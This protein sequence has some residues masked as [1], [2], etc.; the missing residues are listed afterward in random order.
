MAGLAEYANPRNAAAGSLRQLN[1][2]ITARRNLSFRA[3]A[4]G[5]VSELPSDTQ[6]GVLAAMAS[7]GFKVQEHRV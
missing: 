2:I 7:W 6:A 3:Y 5:D 4:W 1:P